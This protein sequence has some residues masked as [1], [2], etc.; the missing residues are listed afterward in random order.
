MKSVMEVTNEMELLIEIENETKS[1]MDAA[2]EM[3][4]PQCKQKSKSVNEGVTKNEI[5]NGRRNK[6]LKGHI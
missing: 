6:V 3:R 4:Y 5:Y 1:L 2:T